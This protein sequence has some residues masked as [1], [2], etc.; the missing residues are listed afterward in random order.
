MKK[1]ILSV[2]VLLIVLSGVSVKAQ[3]V[4]GKF[5]TL[6]VDTS[7]MFSYYRSCNK[8]EMKLLKL[9]DSLLLNKE[10]K[11]ALK[12][13]RKLERK[14][15]GV[16]LYKKLG[17]LYTLDKKYKNGL[18]YYNK[19][20][21]EDR[22]YK[23]AYLCKI[24]IYSLQKDKEAHRGILKEMKKTFPDDISV[25]YNMMAFHI[26][27]QEYD[28]IVLDIA[29]FMKLGDQSAIDINKNSFEVNEFSDI[30][31]NLQ[32]SDLENAPELSTYI[33]DRLLNKRGCSICKIRSIV[34]KYP[35]NVTAAKLYIGR[36]RYCH[37]RKTALAMLKML[38]EEGVAT[39]WQYRRFGNSAYRNKEWKLALYYYN[40]AIENNG[41]FAWTYQ[42]R[43]EVKASM[44]N[45]AGAIEDMTK[46][47]SL[48]NKVAR[49][50]MGRAFAY[51]RL[52]KR[53]ESLKD[54]IKASEMEGGYKAFS[55]I[56][57]DYI[58]RRQADMAVKYADR[59]I[60]QKP[61]DK[62]GYLLKA[63]AYSQINDIDRAIE[64]YEMVISIDKSDMMAVNGLLRIY[65]R[66]KE[67]SRAV[68]LLRDAEG[69]VKNRNRIFH[70]KSGVYMQMRQYEK[71]FEE[72]KKIKEDNIKRRGRIYSNKSRAINMM[73]TILSITTDS[74]LKKKIEAY[75][76]NAGTDSISLKDRARLAERKRDYMKATQ[77][78][79]KALVEAEK[80]ERK[81]ILMSRF[82]CL[83][84]YK[85][86]DQVIKEYDEF[87]KKY[88]NEGLLIDKAMFLLRKGREK[89]GM[90][91]VTECMKGD[92]AEINFRAYQ[93]Y[94]RYSKD[95]KKCE[96]MYSKLLNMH[97]AGKLTRMGKCMPMNDALWIH[98][99]MVDV[100]DRFGCYKKELSLLDTIDKIND[101]RYKLDK[102]RRLPYS[103]DTWRRANIYFKMGETKKWFDLKYEDYKRS[104]K[105]GGR[106]NLDGFISQCLR[107]GLFSEVKMLINKYG[108]GD[109]KYEHY[110]WLEIFPLM[111]AN[112][113][114][115]AEK[116]FEQIL[117]RYTKNFD[118]L[119]MIYCDILDASN[120]LNKLAYRK[121][122]MGL[123]ADILTPMRNKGYKFK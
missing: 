57:S 120:G 106:M 116:K 54:F 117:S 11:K 89:A 105:N 2:I 61:T 40:K 99:F 95:L 9:G 22:Q 33:V 43:G 12:P 88:P 8:K 16:Y 107:G 94:F 102:R 13:L 17:D 79:D 68:S 97:K 50:F 49:F 47:I 7:T 28:N 32:K 58:Y 63:N 48:N 123:N 41:K 82:S 35:D 77:L 69:N 34:Q 39:E 24:A 100:Y 59:A 111:E 115:E 21:K 42:N 72:L 25:L 45:N 90:A 65:E 62:T 81:L 122:L 3:S 4:F 98:T 53:D 75:I 30:L 23:A 96:A 20:I 76:N 121:F 85:K 14:K 64:N 109:K 38:E 80:V 101:K 5:P 56:C 110:C 103:L 119:D 44:K 27:N 66:R 10:F 52:M 70:M 6:Q 37:K 60:Q 55:H 71:A 46:A 51:R 91:I 108:N 73:M 83:S 112:K 104:L 74:K 26:T 18:K 67:Y 86:V 78:Y 29:D 113:F 87:I 1:L 118:M 15:P 19:A 36:D 93:L 92:D 114:K 84:R 31:R